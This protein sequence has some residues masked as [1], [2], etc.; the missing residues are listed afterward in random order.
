MDHW[1]LLYKLE[2]TSFCNRE[3]KL[4]ESFLDYHESLT[5]VQGKFSKKTKNRACSVIQSN[6]LAGIL[7]TIFT[8]EM[9]E[10]R[11]WNA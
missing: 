7:Y 4:I 3:Y 11:Y 9:R 8:L 2:H 6:K 1:L 10:V 5:E